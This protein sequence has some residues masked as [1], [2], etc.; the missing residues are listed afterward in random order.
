LVKDS[1]TALNDNLYKVHLYSH[2]G[3]GTEFFPKLDPSSAKSASA[4]P[5]LLKHHATL[6]KFNVHVEAI[7]E[8]VGCSYFIRDTEMKY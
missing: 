3:L 4:H 2:G 1:S 5:K 8:K 7:L 6:L